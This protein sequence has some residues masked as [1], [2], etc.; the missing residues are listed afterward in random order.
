MDCLP[1][2][3][4]KKMMHESIRTILFHAGTRSTIRAVYR[5]VHVECSMMDVRRR[6][7]TDVI[8]ADATVGRPRGM[9]HDD[10]VHLAGRRRRWREWKPTCRLPPGTTVTIDVF[11][12]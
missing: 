9:R 7:E 5:V 1:Q 12:K 8:R 4:K 2:H 10:E 6:L 3:N 11:R